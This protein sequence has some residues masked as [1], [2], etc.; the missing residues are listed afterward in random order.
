MQKNKRTKSTN[1]TEWWNLSFRVKW[2]SKEERSI[3]SKFE[4]LYVGHGK[5][6]IK[7]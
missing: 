3:N 1:Y 4:I 6:N 5:E 7:T 2:L